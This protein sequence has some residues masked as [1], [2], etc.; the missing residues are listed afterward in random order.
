[1]EKESVRTTIDIP[2]PLYRRLKQQAAARGS[3]VRQLVL[4]S[5]KGVLREQRAPRKRV[6]FPLINSQGPKVEVTGRQIY[7]H[8]EFP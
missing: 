6:R 8:V 7:E 1:M 3:S 2:A 4:A 5:I